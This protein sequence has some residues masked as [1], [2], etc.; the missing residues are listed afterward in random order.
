MTLDS[1]K[2][3]RIK[4][5]RV[6]EYGE[7]YKLFVIKKNTFDNQFNLEEY[8]IN[9]IKEEEKILVDTIKWNGN[10]KKSGIE[11]GDYITEFKIENVNR[12]DKKIIYLIALFLLL[13]FGYLNKKRI[14]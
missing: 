13:F 14:N 8:G 4:V 7:R 12:P 5:T 3:T 1:D 6:S 10:A 9:L 11:L 2:E